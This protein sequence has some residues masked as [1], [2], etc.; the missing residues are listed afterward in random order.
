MKAL[1]CKAFSD[2]LSTLALED[3]A[4]PALGPEDV[5]VRMR[6]A[7]VGFP[8][9]LMTEGKYQF[10][11]EPPYIVGG[12]MAGDVIAVGSA[13][14]QFKIGGRVLGGG[15]YRRCSRKKSSCRPQSQWRYALPNDADYAGLQ[16][17]STSA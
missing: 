13:V 2:D 4:L 8:D 16:P 15:L 17:R 14:T 11:P 1:V 3:I 12:E 10:K 9:L 6:A 5:R 7:T